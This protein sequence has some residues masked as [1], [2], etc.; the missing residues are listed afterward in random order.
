MTFFKKKSYDS[1]I[2][3]SKALDRRVSS[4]AMILEDVN[5]KALIVKATYKT[6]WTFPGGIVD[7]DETPKQAAIRETK[8][9]VGI[10]VN[11]EAVSFVAVITRK[12]ELAQTY[13]FI[14]KTVLTEEMRANIILQTSEIEESLL[15]SKRD[16]LKSDRMYGKVIHHWV[17]NAMGYVEQEF[18][19]S[20]GG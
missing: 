18:S 16:V 5:G 15:V 2:A 6:Y 7:K 9:E 17:D 20:Q 14:F 13:Q 1:F 12:S 11:P 8:E 3:L 19:A 10:L 4:A